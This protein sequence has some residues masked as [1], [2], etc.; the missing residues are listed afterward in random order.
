MKIGRLPA[1]VR[2]T[3]FRLALLH[4]SIFIVF[5]ASLLAY[6]Y[7][8]T[9]GRLD[10]QASSDLNAE[11]QELSNAFRGGGMD[12]LSQSVVERKSARGKFFY[13]LQG[14]DGVK[15]AGDFDILPHSAPPVGQVVD[16]PF[17][18]DAHTPEGQTIRRSAQGRISRLPNGSV[19]MVAYD[20]GDLGE[21]NQRISD[22]VWRSA[23]AGL[24]LS[25]I[26]GVVI[27][28][29]VARR[30]DQLARTTEGVMAGDLSL[31]APVMGSGDEFDRLSSQLNAM[32]GKLERLVISSRSAGDAIA[33]DLRSPLTRLR[34]RLEGGLTQ[35][36]ETA[37]KAA[38]S[39]SIDDVDGVLAT[40]NAIL[41]L[42]RVQAGAAG[43]FRRIDASDVTGQLAELYQPVCEEKGLSFSYSFEPG[44][45]IQ[46]DRDL[47]AQAMSN[48]VDNAAKYTPSP[49]A[50]SLQA[51]RAPTG[52]VELAVVDTGTGIPAE[53]RPRVVERFFR[54]EKSRTEP[55]SGL[56]LS[57]VD[58]V[59]EAHRGRLALSDGGGPPDRPGLSAAL[60]LPAA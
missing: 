40:F 5:S 8:E 10:R 24:V 37:Q 21:L 22:V 49:G 19:L 57:L 30:A 32:L 26:G 28:R 34:N 60:V 50:V 39:N 20:V 31:R 11:F 44:L 7:Y 2:T 52:E 35:T 18:Y 43:S 58:A 6:L 15:I 45:F 47:L 46:A 17:G 13:L 23:A 36:N 56:G 1:L 12:R 59:A 51:K 29:S 33:H 53:D 27:S 9:A 16:V 3:T 25:L 55:G 4:A 41:R 42:S 48:L 38:L 14:P 54:L